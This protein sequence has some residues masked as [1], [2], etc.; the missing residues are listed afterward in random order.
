MGGGGFSDRKS[1]ESFSGI[2]CAQFGNGNSD[3]GSDV[4]SKLPRVQH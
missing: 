1:E 2:L 4:G 3:G